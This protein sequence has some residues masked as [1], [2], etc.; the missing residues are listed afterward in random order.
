MIGQTKNGVQYGGDIILSSRYNRIEKP[1]INTIDIKMLKDYKKGYNVIWNNVCNNKFN[2]N[3]GGDHSISVSTIQPLIDRYKNDLLVIWIDAHADINTIN[4]SLTKNKHGMP[5]SA[6]LG[7]MNHWY[8]KPSNLKKFNNLH[9]NNLIYVGIRD[10]DSYESKIIERNRIINSKL[11]SQSIINTIL[12]NPAKYIHISCDVDSMDPTIMPSTGT[13][14]DGGL[15][16]EDIIDI[17]NCSKKKLIGIDIVEFN[18]LIGSKK[19]VKLT[20]SNINKIIDHV[21]E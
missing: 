8:D 9:K 21:I 11:L 10:L 13:P 4:S 14:V 6:L 18:P 1:N 3:L 2:I 20:L 16:I 7:Y 19:D 12:C 5:L 17:I 15:S